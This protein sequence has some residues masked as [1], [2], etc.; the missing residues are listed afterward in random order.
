MIICSADRTRICDLADNTQYCVRNIQ[1]TF[2]LNEITSL[3]F[4]LPCANPKWKYIECENLVLFN[5]EYYIITTPRFVHSN[6]NK[7]VVEVEAKHLSNILANQL[8]S[9]E[10]ITPMNV[11]DLMRTALCYNEDGQP[12]LGWKVGNVT[13]DRV[14]LRGLEASEQSP[15][16]ILSSNSG[17]V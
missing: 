1:E 14:A 11:V 9:V 15:F 6:D 8:I 5:N 17:K 13:V 10:E 2:A 4:T 7:L 3:T 12:T 16:A